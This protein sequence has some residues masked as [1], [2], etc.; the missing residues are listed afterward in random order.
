MNSFLLTYSNISKL[1]LRSQCLLGHHLKVKPIGNICL[2]LINQQSLYTTSSPLFRQSSS[3]SNNK[4]K[5]N[6]S[7][8]TL[9]RNSL[10]VQIGLPAEKV[11]QGTIVDV[12][13]DELY[14]D[15]GFKFNAIC[16]K[17]KIKYEQVYCSLTINEFS[18][19]FL[20]QTLCSW[21]KSTGADK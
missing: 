20:F 5:Q 16:R 17:P 11:V 7:F 3:N 14:I 9:F 19:F 2:Q 6:T 13:G 15:F 10:L 12:V 8:A 1:S 21:C 4:T 18:L